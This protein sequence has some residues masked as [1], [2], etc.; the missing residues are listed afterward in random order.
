MDVFRTVQK[1]QHDMVMGHAADE[2]VQEL[3]RGSIYPVQ[4]L[5]GQDEGSYLTCSY[6]EVF[7]RLKDPL[8]SSLGLKLQIGLVLH[9]EG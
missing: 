3:L 6:Q 7:Q 4:I 8:L 2:I 5:Y 9:L 1:D